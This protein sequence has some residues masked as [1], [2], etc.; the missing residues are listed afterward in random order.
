MCGSSVL[1]ADSDTVVVDDVR[2]LTP[3]GAEPRDDFT[4]RNQ[5]IQ[6]KQAGGNT[7]HDGSRM[8]D[9]GVDVVDDHRIGTTQQILRNLEP[10]RS[11]GSDADDQGPFSKPGGLKD[12]IKTRR[13][14]DDHVGST[15]RLL[16]C[17]GLSH[18]EPVLLA[19]SADQR[20]TLCRVG[21]P[22][23]H[24]GQ[25]QDSRYGANVFPRLHTWPEDRK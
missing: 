19:K 15:Y 6:R 14:T 5:R 22:D 3:R 11:E 9:R 17:Q 12:R 10:V 23:P 18:V 21:S 1:N 24:G 7:H 13:A 4:Q 25:G 2:W 8:L 20:G 16:R